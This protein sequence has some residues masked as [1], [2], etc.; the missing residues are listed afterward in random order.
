MKKELSKRALVIGIIVIFIGVSVSPVIQGSNLKTDSYKI[1]VNNENQDTSFITFHTFD[2]SGSKKCGVEL[3]YNAVEEIS[4]MFEDLEH[5]IIN[6]P[7]SS[8]TKALKSDFVDLLESYDLFPAG[9][10]KNKVLSLLNPSWLSWF[11]KRPYFKTSKALKTGF[12]NI[13][14]V[15]GNLQRFFVSSDI[16]ESLVRYPEPSSAAADAFLCNII[17]WGVG[18]PIPLFMLPRPRGIALWYAPKESLTNVG[19]LV[20]AS[21]FQAKGTQYGIALGFVGLGLSFAVLGEFLYGIIG[22]SVYVY[23]NADEITSIS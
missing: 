13:F 5:K 6:E 21:G 9:M 17:S 12:F 14:N 23:I 15:L 20:I 4:S 11:E 7:F 19:Q 10:S 2:K 3:S 16:I 22:Y 1:R 18:V 8:E